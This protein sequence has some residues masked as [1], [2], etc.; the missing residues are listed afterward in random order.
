[1]K[2]DNITSDLKDFLMG[3]FDPKS[4]LWTRIALFQGAPL[5]NQLNDNKKTRWFFPILKKHNGSFITY[6][7]SPDVLEGPKPLP[8]RAIIFSFPTEEDANN[9]WNDVDYQELSKH[10]RAGTNATIQ[11]IKG[12]P[13]RE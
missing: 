4:N 8:G 6:D 1:M 7:D 13:P 12:L 3:K 2:E 10:R 5:P 9:W 11:R